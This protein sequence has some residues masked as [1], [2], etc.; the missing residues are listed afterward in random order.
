MIKTMKSHLK[1]ADSGDYLIIDI[2]SIGIL[3][4]PVITQGSRDKHARAVWT[5][6]GD[7][8]KPTLKPSIKTQK[9]LEKEVVHL[10]LND[11]ICK[12]LSDTTTDVANKELP[13]NDLPEWAT[14]E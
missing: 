13:L 14:K 10:W 11:G 12:F 7:L 6:N 9:G 5:W 2:P 3:T 4:L 8:E 1:K